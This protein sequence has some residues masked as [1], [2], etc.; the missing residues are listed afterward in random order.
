MITRENLTQE[1]ISELE[2]KSKQWGGK[3]IELYTKDELQQLA[4][5]NHIWLNGFSCINPTKEFAQDLGFNILKLLEHSQMRDSLGI[6][7]E[8]ILTINKS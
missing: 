6:S 1:E 3:S 4:E 2:I 5:S 7:K 8:T